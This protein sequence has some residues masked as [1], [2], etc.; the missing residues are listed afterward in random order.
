MFV[1]QVR[2]SVLGDA[3][4]RKEIQT[5]TNKQTIFQSDKG[6]TQV[7]CSCFD[8]QTTSKIIFYL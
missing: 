4:M 5:F 8:L 2:Y 6:P 3:C 7:V 1:L